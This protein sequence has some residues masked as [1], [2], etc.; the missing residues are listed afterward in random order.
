MNEQELGIRM[1]EFERDQAKM[2]L[3]PAVPRSMSQ[4]FWRSSS[5]AAGGK[6]C[7]LYCRKGPAARDLRT[8]KDESKLIL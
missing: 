4:E 6:C 7:V 5:I 2:A 1:L 3:R 8:S